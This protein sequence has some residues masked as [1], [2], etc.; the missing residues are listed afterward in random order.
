MVAYGSKGNPVAQDPFQQIV[1]VHWTAPY[2][3]ARFAIALDTVPEDDIGGTG[4]PPFVEP[5][6]LYSTTAATYAYSGA[7]G[8]ALT[9]FR[10]LSG[11]SWNNITGV[12]VADAPA[13]PGPYSFGKWQ[14]NGIDAFGTKAPFMQFEAGS[15]GEVIDI[16]VPGHSALK[17]NDA[18]AN[19]V[20]LK[21]QGYAEGGP[22]DNPVIGQFQKWATAAVTGI[23]P[24]FVRVIQD[25]ETAALSAAG[26]TLTYKDKTYDAIGAKVAPP[27]TD[28]Q[29]GEFWVLFRRHRQ[30]VTP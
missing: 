14:W 4:G 30:E 3:A 22:Y 5:F 24:N 18:L 16:P 7:S 13:V 20:I 11:K 21:A 9:D 1:A 27:E 25:A 29:P 2:I 28:F 17:F 19:N 15:Q 26:M 8:A 12:D 6:T 10:A 23:S